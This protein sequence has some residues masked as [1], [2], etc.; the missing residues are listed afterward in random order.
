MPDDPGE[1]ATDQ[2]GSAQDVARTVRIAARTLARAG[3]AQ[4][5]GHVS[6]RLD[7]DRFVVC[8]PVAMGL[9]R[10]GAACSTVPVHGDLPQ[11]VL[12]EVR[13]HQSIY[14]RRPD[15]GAVCR[16]QPANVMT[17]S[18]MRLLPRP[19][20]GPGCYVAPDARSWDDVQLLR[21]RGA[22]DALAVRLGTSS[23]IVLRGNGAVVCSSSLPRAVV[24]SWFLEEA[25]RVEVDHV[26]AGTA[27]SAPVIPDHEAARR[28][29]WSGGIET[30]TW[31]Y[32]TEG[33]PEV[34]T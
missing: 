1:P 12:G 8:P 26:L 14:A 24:L 29:T 6:A 20:H 32:L 30:R 15:V 17:L 11:G 7:E 25:A 10:P 34:L 21:D 19:R 3:L 18:T 9:V 31:A 28:A 5:F 4:A 2:A 13:I 22:T 33:D 23:V 27:G 16:V